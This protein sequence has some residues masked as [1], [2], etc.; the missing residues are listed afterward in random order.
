MLPTGEET[1]WGFI[2]TGTASLA[3]RSGRRLGKL[4]SCPACWR[5]RQLMDLVTDPFEDMNEAIVHLVQKRFQIEEMFSM[6][7]TPR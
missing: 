2:S 7:I 6:A 1:I 4:V 3:H 5:R